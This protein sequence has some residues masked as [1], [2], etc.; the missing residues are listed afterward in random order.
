MISR[1]NM[2]DVKS[3]PPPG[4]NV[5]QPV[6]ETALDAVVVMG[7]DGRV[8][9]W[10]ARAE[11]V[12]GWKREEAMGRDMAE[13]I[14]PERM[15]AAHHAGLR[16][17]LSGGPLHILGRMVEL[18]ALRRNGSEFPVELSITRPELAEG[19]VF[20]AFIRDISARK[21]D[22]MSLR[23][24]ERR[25]RATQDHA[26]VGIAE[27]GA[28]GGFLRVNPSFCEITGLTKEELLGATFLEF[29]HPDDRARDAHLFA[30]QVAGRL[31]S[32]TVEKRYRRSDG[33]DIWVSV[34]ASP[35]RDDEGGFLFGVRILQDITA[36]RAAEQRQKLLMDEVNHRV[37][38]TLA[39]VLAMAS[40]TGVYA[41]D[42]DAF[43][44]A[45]TARIQALAKSHGLLTR[46]RWEGAPLRELLEAE[47]TLHA[48]E[49]GQIRL[50]GPS[51]WLD[52]RSA[53]D[54]GLI[55]H[56]LAA[57]A[58]KHGALSAGG[59]IEVSWSL[60]GAEDGRRVKLQWR[61]RGGPQVE[62]PKRQGFGSKLINSLARDNLGGEAVWRFEP[63]GLGVDVVFLTSPLHAGP[64]R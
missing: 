13:L 40:Q 17:V 42:L 12:F 15:R 54:V 43:R 16:R 35:V 44:R 53:V 47:L 20:L 32:Y 14:I 37:N 28:S 10:N 31:G 49:P 2:S 51:V 7:T 59:T 50:S 41:A 24:A 55:V 34:N 4:L 25:L 46:E 36:R 8:L 52:P 60:L 63:G 6:L 30:E 33:R 23:K 22:E 29:T 21:R 27:V 5:L 62:A 3:S 26:D 61:E 19:Q 1:M 64:R 11:D 39:I 56:E 58:A 9:D 18:S 48:L 57:N 38:N 45:F